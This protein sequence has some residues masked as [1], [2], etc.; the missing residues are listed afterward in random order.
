MSSTVKPAEVQNVATRRVERLR[1]LSFAEVSELPQR[2]DEM[3]AVGDREVAVATYR[4]SL[5][6]GR[7]RVV[8]QAYFH[9]FLGIGTMTADGFIIAP[10]STRTPV[11]Q[12]MMW[13][14]V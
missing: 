9:R 12:E 14:F 3:E 2:Q 8:V 11:P 4:D 7:I 13:E 1:L 10:D 5:P 6:D